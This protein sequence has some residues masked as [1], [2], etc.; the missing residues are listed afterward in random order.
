M[1]SHNIIT[2]KDVWNPLGEQLAALAVWCPDRKENHESQEHPTPFGL[3]LLHPLVCG[4]CSPTNADF[5]F[6]MKTIWGLP[7]ARVGWR[8][9]WMHL[10]QA[11][12]RHIL[13]GLTPPGVPA[14]GSFSSPAGPFHC[15]AWGQPALCLPEQAFTAGR[16]TATSSRQIISTALQSKSQGG[17]KMKSC[18]LGNLNPDCSNNWFSQLWECC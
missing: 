9:G 8:S 4:F 7:K 10:L 2:S 16:G 18:H 13:T 6:S 12:R 14:A 11:Q 17:D 3:T 5:F 15:L 1:Y